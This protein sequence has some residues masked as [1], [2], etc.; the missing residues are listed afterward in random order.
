M[1]FARGEVR[2]PEG[3]L[4]AT[5]TGTWQLWPHRPGVRP[6]ATGP[7][8]VLRPRG[9]RITVGKILAVGLNYAKHIEE[10]G[11]T[12]AQDPV[13]FFKP[14]SALL[15]AIEA[16]ITAESRPRYFGYSDSRPNSRRVS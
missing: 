7:W 15:I 10:M 3:R 8:I 11:S 14:P 12:P 2:T 16:I 13:I 4:I 6:P 5:A 9:E 1:A